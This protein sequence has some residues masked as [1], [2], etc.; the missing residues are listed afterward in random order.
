MD[1]PDFPEISPR[2]L[3]VI[4]DRHGAHAVARLPD[5][6]I[7]NAVY[8]LGDDLVLRVPR[9]HATFVGAA[10]QEAIAAPAARAVGV[11][12]PRLVEFDESRAVLP[13]PYLVY[14]RVHGETLG[15]LDL[16][17]TETPTVWREL[18]RDL[19]LLHSRVDEAGEVGTLSADPLPDPRPWAAELDR[20]GQIGASEARWLAGWLDRLAPAALVPVRRRFLHGDVQSTNVM[21][22]PGARTYLA[23][24]DWG[25]A[26]WGDA[27]WDF[28][29]IPLRAVPFV[30]EGHRAVAPLDDD[31]TA[32][33]RILWR[34][35][36]LALYLLRRPPQPGRSWAERPTG[37]L[38]EVLRF[39]LGRPDGRWRDLAP[40]RLG[41]P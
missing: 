15:A 32:E 5:V 18:G 34:H 39:F 2:A 11:R 10:C 3:R 1:L 26:K 8:L 17:P 12:T 37:M 22:R 9:D 30:L 13:V 7:F 19:A 4:A 35:L 38:V 21:V 33:V 40:D 16:E 36:Q 25:D 28:A 29:G 23:L 14:E 27:A 31:E 20:G 41:R 6:G 24:I